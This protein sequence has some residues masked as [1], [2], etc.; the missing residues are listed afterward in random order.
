MSEK[1]QKGAEARALSAHDREHRAE[2]RARRAKASGDEIGARVH[3]ESAKLHAR[4]AEAAETLR[5]LDAAV[6]SSRPDPRG[7]DAA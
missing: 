5:Q 4:S 2:E 3:H 7:D 6:E 1:V